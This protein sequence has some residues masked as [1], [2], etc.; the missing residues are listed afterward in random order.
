MPEKS[1]FANNAGWRKGGIGEKG[2]AEM[3]ECPK[4]KSAL[5]AITPAAADANNAADQEIS[6]SPGAGSAGWDCSC[7]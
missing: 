4:R 5:F 2:G 6:D 7:V 3:E 1:A